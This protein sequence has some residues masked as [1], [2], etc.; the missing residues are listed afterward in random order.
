MVAATEVSLQVRE[1]G[2]QRVEL[3]RGAR[4]KVGLYRLF[5]VIVTLLQV[6]VRRLLRGPRH[7]RWDFRYE[8]AVSVL[9]NLSLHAH[10]A[11]VREL[12]KY[13]LT[14][15]I[16]SSL[17][18]SVAHALGSHSG[19]YAESYA[20]RTAHGA[21]TLLY[22]HGGGYFLC[23]PAT[24]RDLISRLAVACAART[25]AVDYRKAPEYPYPAA[26]DDCEHAY[27][28]LLAEGVPPEQII[29]AGDSAGAGL[30]L[31]VLLRTRDA[32]LPAPGCAILL[33]PWCDLT[34]SGASIKDNAHYDYLTADGLGL[35]AETYLQ[36]QDP[37]HPHVS[38]VRAELTG[39]PPLLVVTGD[40][41]LFYS[42][43]LELVARARA[44]GVAV[45]HVV[46]PG[47]VHVSALFAS[48]AP[49]AAATFAH[50]EAFV[51]ERAAAV[52]A[53]PPQLAVAG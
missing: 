33:S 7:E 46:E 43:N 1:S 31:A 5:V 4:L 32:G 29:L 35:G 17:R 50:V 52:P 41:E 25:I 40:A 22:F 45:T 27:R 28:A 20:P 14:S 16:P 36:G 10:G 39:L 42:E 23:S 11:P 38:H 51:A 24:H 47:G 26:I 2:V 12:R 8:L 53:H 21:R 48:L 49:S 15:E 19:L 3:T 9:R 30:A 44:Q 18:E 37:Q 6:S 13:V 34:R